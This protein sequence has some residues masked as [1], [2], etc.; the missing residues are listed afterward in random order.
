MIRFRLPQAVAP[1][2]LAVA[3]AGGLAAAQA[4]APGAPSNDAWRGHGGGDRTGM[5][6]DR[7]ADMARRHAQMIA[8]WTLVLKLTPGQAQALAT[9]MQ[10]PRPMGEAMNRR[11]AEASAP[12]GTLQHL[13]AIQARMAERDTHMR[14]HL[15]AMRSFYTSLSPE[16]QRTF[17]AMM[18]L[19]HSGMRR[20]GTRE[21]RG[22]G[23]F[24][25]HGGPGG[26][27]PPPGE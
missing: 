22:P 19:S 23:G 3:L 25:R 12:E 27:P 15:T 20:R 4:P 11:G 21:G 6:A 1:L 5:R 14:A 8:D 2:A 13:D 24:G 17:D 16:Q 9:V 7:R 26:P 18:R 10:P